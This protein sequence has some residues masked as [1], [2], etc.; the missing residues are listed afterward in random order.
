ML[1]V[2][3]ALLLGGGGIDSVINPLLV[4]LAAVGVLAMLLAT[5]SGFAVERRAAPLLIVLV[6]AV[7]LPAL[8]M[9]PLPPLVWALLPGRSVAVQAFDLVGASAKWHP[10]SLDPEATGR[11]ALAL[12]PAVAA[13]LGVLCLD[14]PQ[15]YRLVI[16]IVG[17]AFAGALFSAIQFA[18]GTGGGLNLYRLSHYGVGVGFFANRN[19]DADLLLIAPLLAAAV[20]RWDPWGTFGSRARPAALILLGVFALG[21]LTTF[22]RTGVALLAPVAAIV[23]LMSV[24]IRDRRMLLAVLGG[25][26]AVAVALGLVLR[27]NGVIGGLLSRFS[28][29]SD[30]RFS[31]WPDVLYAIRQYLPWG[32][33]LGTFDPVFRSVEQLDNVLAAYVVHAHNDYAELALETGVPGLILVAAGILSIGAALFERGAIARFRSDPVR[34]ASALG[35][36]V[37]L[38]HSLVDYPLRTVALSTLFGVLCALLVRPASLLR[39]A[40]AKV[41]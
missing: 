20:L 27:S 21:V 39:D 17:I 41:Q 14:Y 3:M 25:G 6:L 13:F 2:A 34:L 18:G 38:L 4:E 1:L 19:H 26:V 10:L 22:S 7:L 30:E 5:T 15:R 36:A 35:I 29:Q 31:F 16:L 28:M 11:S 12:L 33:G 23:V 8:Q 9:V 24:R 32:S 37:L 40:R